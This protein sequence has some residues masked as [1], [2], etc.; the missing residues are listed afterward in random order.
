MNDV[1]GI[2]VIVLVEV[3]NGGVDVTV[4]VTTCEFTDVHPSESIEYEKSSIFNY[5]PIN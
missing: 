5:L 4:D 2:E 3:L 1:F